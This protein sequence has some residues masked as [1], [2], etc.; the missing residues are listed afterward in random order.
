MQPGR[1]VDISIGTLSNLAGQAASAAAHAARVS[2]ASQARQAGI[3]SFL[4][5]VSS[6]TKSA[7]S[8]TVSFMTPAMELQIA[9]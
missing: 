6:L 9:W 3:Y 5:R 7:S 2:V 4:P 1:A 8:S